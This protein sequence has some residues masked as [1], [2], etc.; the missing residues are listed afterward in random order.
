MNRALSLVD[1]AD[2]EATDF[3][4]QQAA[5]RELHRGKLLCLGCGQATTFRTGSRTRKPFFAARHEDS[6]ALMRES[7][8]VFRYLQ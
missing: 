3:S 8:T 1:G 6:W 7:W 4:A 5:W 2:W